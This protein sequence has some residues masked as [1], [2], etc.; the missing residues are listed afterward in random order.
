M[1][2][3]SDCLRP[4]LGLSFGQ[5]EQKIHLG[6]ATL[7]HKNLE[8]KHKGIRK[9]EKIKNNKNSDILQTQRNNLLKTSKAVK[10]SRTLQPMPY[11]SKLKITVVSWAQLSPTLSLFTC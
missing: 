5:A 7:R 11:Q 9:L 10:L 8:K 4:V 3:W 2:G 1:L 6:K